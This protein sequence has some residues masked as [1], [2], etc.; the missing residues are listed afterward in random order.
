[1]AN[2]VK[3]K[4]KVG[5]ALEDTF[6]GDASTTPVAMMINEFSYELQDNVV[7][8]ES[9]V[10][11]TYKYNHAIRDTQMA[12]FTLNAKVDENTLPLFFAQKFGI[13][14]NPVGGDSGAYEHVL[15]Y[16]NNNYL[17]STKIYLDDTDR[18][19]DVFSGMLFSSI[20]IIP[21]TNQFVRIEAEGTCLYAVES[22]LTLSISDTT[23]EF[24]SRHSA[25]SLV[26]S[27]ATFASYDVK[28]ANYNH[29]FT[30]SDEA[31]NFSLGS[32]DMQ[33]QFVNEDEYTAE[34]TALMSDKT[35]RGYKNAAT[36]LKYKHVMTD[37]GRIISG[38]TAST[39]P[40]ITFEYPRAVITELVERDGA[41]GDIVK[42]NFTLT[43]LDV[44][45][46]SDCPLKITV[47]NNVASY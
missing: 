7:L 27:G 26:T 11:S 4:I 3:R 28:T 16:S 8:N 47:R 30:L 44:P 40:I 15:A 42:Q 33:A 19:G 23:R 37:T 41:A 20:N 31:T 21:E 36:M 29:E 25:F 17:K 39:S 18:T 13:T 22:G 32:A 34:L 5:M 10:G 9:A 1:M 45:S 6:G 14:S 43:A 2:G 38:S 46:V 35:L 12:T 24:V